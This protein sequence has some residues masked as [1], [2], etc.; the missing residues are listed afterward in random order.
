MRKKSLLNSL[1]VAAGLLVG[2]NA[3]AVTET[4]T[5]L[6]EDYE[7]Y[8]VGDITE[9][10]KAN[11][12]NFQSRNGNNQITIKQ[13][14]DGAVNPTKYFD[15]YYPDGGASRNQSWNF[16]VTSSLN[17][18]NWKLTFSAALNPGTNN[19]ANKFYI[20]G[21]SSGKVTSAND[22]ITNPLF[23]LIGTAAASVEYTPSL[24]GTSYDNI[25][26]TSGEWYKFT[27]EATNIDADAKT[28]DIAVT[29]T[30]YSGSTTVFSQSIAGQSTSSFGQLQ[31]IAWNSPRGYSRL[32]LD[33]VLLTKEVDASVCAEPTYTITG[34]AGTARKFTLACETNNSVIYYATSELA[35]G[36]S[37]WTEYT[38]E[39]TTEAETIYAYAAKGAV[40]SEIISFTTG[41]GEAITLNAPVISTEGLVQNGSAFNIVLNASYNKVGVEFTPEATI[42]ATFTPLGGTAANVELPFTATESGILTVTATAEGFTS[43]ET[44]FEVAGSYTQSWQSLDFSTIEDDPDAVVEALGEGWGKLADTGRWASWSADNAPYSYYQ[45]TE[46]GVSVPNVT[47]CE[48]LRMRNVVVLNVGYGLGRNITGGEAVNVL[49]TKAGEVI[50]FKMYNGYGK[51]TPN[52]ENTY[53]TYALS[54]GSSNPYVNTN[55]ANV[56]VQATIYSPVV[57]E[58]LATID[59]HGYA[60]FSSAYAVN[61]DDVE[62]YYASAVNESTVTLKRATG[63]VKA[64][65]GLVLSAAS[66]GNI[67]LPVVESGEAIEGNL[68][69]GCTKATELAAGSADCYVLS[70]NDDDVT[71][72]Q[73]LAEWEEAVTVPAGHAYLK[74]AAASSRLA[75]VFDSTTTGISTVNA[76]P[77]QNAEVYNLQGQRVEKAVKGLYI[78]NGKKVLK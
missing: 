42:K 69:V 56:L 55:N 17:D 75:I 10:M 9:T 26:L 61:V 70:F 33:D 54:N 32:N 35:K 66:A 57:T 76:Q 16:G 74:A 64:G 31:G 19:S 62:A 28:A 41:A 34:A 11:G 71:E 40:T 68:L 2:A 7:S 51:A 50:A 63:D 8:A 24:A 48:K 3:W 30:D 13:G 47:V 1:L 25:T 73:S 67:I 77:Q 5:V 45:Y 78:V 49:N 65:T 52:N 22:D 38:A 44:N 23:S 27:V 29:I 20:V 53:V 43:A 18:D 21:T 37:G 6:S 39:V 15:F 12:W 60:T 4:V 46:E 36:A 14:A 58:V 59:D 72:F